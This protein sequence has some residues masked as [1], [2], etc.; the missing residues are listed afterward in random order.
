MVKSFL[1]AVT[2]KICINPLVQV[3]RG[4]QGQIKQLHMLKNPRQICSTKKE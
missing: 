4:V 3:A 2:T 1:I